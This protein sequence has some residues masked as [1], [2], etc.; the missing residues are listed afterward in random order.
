MTRTPPAEVRAALYRAL[1]LIGGV[2]VRQDAVDAAG[3]HGV[4]FA[5]TGTWQRS[6]IIVSTDDY[7]F[8]GTYGEAVADRTFPSE[9]VGTVRAGTP[10]A[11]TA[12]LESGVVD[13][14][15]VRPGG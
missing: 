9:K 14:P 12:Y 6:E 4:A 3:R 10:L 2:T 8:L 1:P 11:W 13:R 15:G 5:Y 7:R